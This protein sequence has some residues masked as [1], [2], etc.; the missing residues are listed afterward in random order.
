M[1]EKKRKD[2]WTAEED[3]LLYELIFKKIERGETQLSGF[4]EAGIVLGRSKQACAFRWNKYLRPFHLQRVVPPQETP[5]TSSE[6]NYLQLAMESYDEMKQSYVQMSQEY[7][8]LKNDYEQLV[9]WVKQG[10]AKIEK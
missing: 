3:N 10:I 7:N 9:N 2:S 8:L 6:Q 5:T 1:S 4:E